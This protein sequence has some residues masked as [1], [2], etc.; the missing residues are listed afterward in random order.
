MTGEQGLVNVSKSRET[1]E[2]RRKRLIE[3]ARRS[4][5][6]SP[7]EQDRRG[8]I[9][10]HLLDHPE[11]AVLHPENI[12]A[13]GVVVL[14]PSGA[15]VKTLDKCAV[16]KPPPSEM[17][18]KVKGRSKKARGRLMQHLIQVDLED[19]AAERKGAKYGAAHF[20][21]L[22]YPWTDGKPFTDYERGK[23]HLEALRK[24]IV[25]KCGLT[26]AVW[27]Q[28]HQES[29]ALHFHLVVLLPKVVK[30]AWFR[31]WLAKAWY[32]VVGSGNPDHLRA[33]TSLEAVYVEQGQ[34][35]NLLGYLSKELG[36][37]KKGY[38]VIA[39]DPETGE[40]LETGKTWGIWG[41]EAFEACKVL[42]ASIR[43]K[44]GEYWQRFKENV[45]KRFEK[46]PYLR[47]V[48]DMNWWGG[49]LLYGNGLELLE[50]LLE[51][52]PAGAWSFT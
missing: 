34:P 52:I 30:V 16:R 39:F 48:A 15:Q 38:Q 40:A 11:E 41:R 42:I 22:T 1:P 8:E 18:R 12:A 20:V 28:E 25:Y 7:E 27:V 37:F 31:A 36:G 32:E 26:W 19:I 10:A 14:H 49:G 35:G 24:R 33:G 2:A 3:D 23:A 9:A 4:G 46:S 44:G 21:T 5:G 50:D 45:S 29:T 17:G 13:D 6:R 51:G 47:K 43:I